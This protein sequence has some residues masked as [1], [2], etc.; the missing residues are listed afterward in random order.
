MKKNHHHSRLHVPSGRRLV[1]VV[2]S[3]LC[4]F[5]I[6]NVL[7]RYAF[8]LT[9]STSRQAW[10]EKFT[11]TI[12]FVVIAGLFC[13]WLEYL[14]TFFCDHEHHMWAGTVYRNKSTFST[15]N[16]RVI[17]WYN[18]DNDIA[19][20]VR[21][22]V[23]MDVSPMFPAYMNLKRNSANDQNAPYSNP[24]YQD[25]IGAQNYTS[26][27]DAWLA[28]RMTTDPGLQVDQNGNLVSC[29]LPNQLN[30][31]GAPCF[32]SE[33]NLSLANAMGYKGN[34]VFGIDYILNNCSSL[35]T[36][37]AQGKG[38]V[39]L[40][41]LVLDVTN[42]LEYATNMVLVT[43]NVH[44]R[45]FAVDRMFLPLDITT[46]LYLNLG[47]D[48]TTYFDNNNISNAGIY[49]QCLKDMFY[50][51]ITAN[52]IEEGC[53]KVNPALWA[54]M[55]CGLLYFFIKM[56]LANLSR[57]KWVQ[58]RLFKSN[59]LS[60]TKV[61]HPMSISTASL[62]SLK[63][64]HLQEN[65]DSSSV[66]I[67][68]HA[69]DMATTAVIS[70]S[71]T[72][73]ATPSIGHLS[74]GMLSAQHTP[75]T[76]M[77]IPCY[78]ETTDTIRSTLNSLARNNYDD[79]HKLLVFVCDGVVQSATEN[80]PTHLSVLDALGYSTREEASQPHAYQS[81]GQHRRKVNFA[82]VYAG[83]YESGRNR[84]PFLVI[85]KVGGPLEQQ[86]RHQPP[87]A[88]S[89]KKKRDKLVDNR[90]PGNR[91]KRD[92]L[93]IILSFLERCMH[94]AQSR[95]SPLEYELFNQC[96][97]VLG[98]DPRK[99][100]YMLVTDADTQV[101]SDVMVKM[102]GR[103]EADRRLLAISGHVRPANPE[104]NIFTILQI[105]PVYAAFF[106]GLAYEA[107][108]GNVLT[109]NGNLVMY[110]LWWE[111]EPY[112]QLLAN[113]PNGTPPPTIVATAAT[114]PPGHN[115]QRRPKTKV[116]DEIQ[117]TLHDPHDPFATL[118]RHS[119]SPSLTSSISSVARSPSASMVSHLSFS[120]NLRIRPYC[121]HPTVLR[122]F[123]MPEPDTM[124]MK[125][126]LLLGEDQYFGTVLL[127]SF[128]RHHLGFEP[129]A[130]GY[131]TIPTRFWALQALQMRT[132]RA[133]FHNQL[134]MI[135]VSGQLG[136]APWF[137]S[138]T[139]IADM[140]LSLPIMVYL[141]G[142]FVRCFLKRGLAY[143]IISW[144]FTGLFVL[145]VLYFL[146]RRQFKYVLWFFIYCT[147][148]VPL[149]VIWFPLAA[150]WTS[151]RA[152][153]WYDVWPT[154][155]G[156]TWVARY[157]GC[158]DRDYE[159]QQ[160]DDSPI[161][162]GKSP[163]ELQS[164]P[165]I[166]TSTTTHEIK[167]DSAVVPNDTGGN[168]SPSPSPSPPPVITIPR[169]LLVDYERLEAQ[170][171]YDRAREEAAVLDAK[172]T[173]FT[174][175]ATHQHAN[176]V[177]DDP[178][179]MLTVKTNHTDASNHSS[180]RSSNPFVHRHH[181]GHPDGSSA[182]SPPPLAQ[183]RD[184]Y[185]SL[186]GLTATS[187]YRP[188]LETNSL[189]RRAVGGHT[190]ST[191]SPMPSP[192]PFSDPISGFDDPFDDGL[193]AHRTSTYRQYHRR[194]P[195]PSTY[196]YYDPGM[197]I[198]MT[199]DGSTAA[200]SNH[201]SNANANTPSSPS[202]VFTDP[203]TSHPPTQDVSQ[204]SPSSTAPSSAAFAKDAIHA[205]PHSTLSQKSI[206]SLD[207]AIE[208]DQHA[209]YPNDDDLEGRSMAVH[210]HVGLKIPDRTTVYRQHQRQ[211]SVSASVT[212]SHHL[213][214]PPSVSSS[215]SR[216]QR[217]PG[218]S[219]TSFLD[220][221]QLEIRAYLSH[222]DLDATTRA[223]VKEHLLSV[224]GDRMLQEDL[225]DPINSSI[226]DIT[227]ELLTAPP[228]LTSVHF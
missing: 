8:H 1:W 103:L 212:P 227:L 211:P 46:M 126:V 108:L 64:G 169:M 36:P 81:L 78:A 32:Y 23:G 188:M 157:H 50:A 68:S 98:L 138:V 208:E 86:Q 42:Y 67:I 223:Q 58:R 39:V 175:F 189:E 180:P 201:S 95:M 173:G 7:L 43:T 102:V 80:K 195:S 219:S 186:R 5:F 214:P 93:L 121:I 2:L 97:H 10:R 166:T 161:D 181:F 27:A 59:D 148:G 226:E 101:Q 29:P 143:Y 131:A 49:R 133:S 221:V 130:V 168:A 142:V 225:Q 116:S 129:E 84:V 152:D 194:Q 44:S 74:A 40:D 132:I 124:H 38:F 185:T 154:G 6:P 149:F 170:R 55:G 52:G 147:L 114:Q 184:G 199:V 128:P 202:S 156:L 146:L 72:P 205:R 90:A 125:N 203:Y 24:Q 113:Y 89:P 15:V 198:P 16:G 75:H 213:P 4:T 144:S 135:R 176:A 79:S 26:Q 155:S 123:A 117:P 62:V 47:T 54:T 92:S 63:P 177:M 76:L 83:F 210:G 134:E 112:T 22:Y 25:C 171:A 31:T 34:L 19:M 207:L 197:F 70:P 51:G 71:S 215:S 139:K 61:F 160:R 228:P 87:Q 30:T 153:R 107:F 73:T 206:L 162:E 35:S 14:S 21:P 158:I 179:A 105:F 100:K 119:S 57:I 13:V 110:K 109:I 218:N 174:A 99:F 217:T 88:A 18:D 45:A 136:F 163:V 145:Q 204:P 104:Q 69:A 141:Y 66:R 220:A 91:G 209:G 196:P 56:N 33:A 115:Q 182:P 94:L 37:S 190:R 127:R 11:T 120:A 151:D 172:F 224:F 137:L 122:G 28:Y 41:N 3:A 12:L 216:R 187:S 9:S 106:T 178:L 192:N 222:A 53:L 96:Y 167:S 77:L 20:A 65:A 118:P 159:Q 111:D 193:S 165:T 183:I 140:I 200:P 164:L 150:L 17:D 82:K 48:I 85:V 60:P 191:S